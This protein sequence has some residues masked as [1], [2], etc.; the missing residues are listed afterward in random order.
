MPKR[1]IIDQH[2]VAAR[3][4]ARQSLGSLRQQK[5]L[6]RTY[7]RYRVQCIAFLA[8]C[9]QHQWVPA[10]SWEELDFQPCDYIES[11][12]SRGGARN[13]AGDVLS[14]TQFFLRTRRKIPAAWELLRIW[15]RTELPQRVPPMP[16]HVLL[17]MV[18][19]CVQ[20][21]RLD[22]AA[23]LLVGFAA[24]LRTMEALTLKRAQLAFAAA[25]D[26]LVIS[27]PH[28]KSGQRRGVLETVAITEPALVRLVWHLVG[29]A[30]PHEHTLKTSVPQ[31][32]RDFHAL[33][34]HLHVDHPKLQPYS[35]RR[36][37]A[38]TYFLRT[39]SYDKVADRGRWGSERTARIY[40]AEGPALLASMLIPPA[41]Q[42]RMQQLMALL[43]QRVPVGLRPVR[44]SWR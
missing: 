15:E 35:L 37:G 24:F 5:I 27:L 42:L 21:S 26:N 29:H 40:I 3:L 8:F 2:T 10:R 9:A 30:A 20:Q 33:L 4:R 36:G 11:L 41:A 44:E 22:L 28:T 14:G 39:Q 31:F 13:A 32:R 25:L 16:E 6:P 23:V 19:V 7:E 1:P 12:W 38:T 18:E 17:A 43:A 34:L